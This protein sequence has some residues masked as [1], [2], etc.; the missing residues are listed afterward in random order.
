MPDIFIQILDDRHAL[1]LQIANVLIKLHT[2]SLDTDHQDSKQITLLT[3]HLHNLQTI[4]HY[5]KKIISMFPPLE[6][7]ISITTE[8]KIPSYLEQ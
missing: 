3:E 8:W 4:D 5:Y 6:I 7:P 2:A 1:F